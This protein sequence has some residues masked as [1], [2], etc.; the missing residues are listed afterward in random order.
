[1]Q[2]T[3]AAAVKAPV[4]LRDPM[5]HDLH[6]R[7]DR[8][9]QSAVS[10]VTDIAVMKN[11]MEYIKTEMASVTGGIKKL[12][13]IAVASGIS[14]FCSVIGFLLVGGQVII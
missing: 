14:I 2:D 4:P 13:W 7:V 5:V 11:D 12:L 8:L 9:E 3:N 1:M 10:Q 6:V